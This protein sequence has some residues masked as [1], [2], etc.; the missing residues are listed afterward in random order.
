MNLQYILLAAA[1]I[2]ACS[3][4]T[5]VAGDETKLLKIQTPNQVEPNDAVLNNKNTRLLRVHDV[6]TDDEERGKG[7]LGQS[8]IVKNI[9]THF[10]DVDDY[11][12][13]NHA[14][15]NGITMIGKANPTTDFSMVTLGKML[16]ESKFKKQVFKRWDEFSMDEIRSK[17]GSSNLR[18]SK[19][20]AM[21]DDYVNNFRKTRRL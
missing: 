19:V 18:D 5:S 10:D 11:V 21:L 1:A 3:G 2:L 13:V 20:V 9:A 4:A 7:W 14:N 16:Q 12:M 8:S 17:L 6:N 15:H